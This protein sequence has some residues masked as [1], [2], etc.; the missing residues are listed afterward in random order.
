MLFALLKLY[1]FWLVIFRIFNLAIFTQE[2]Q[3][4]WLLPAD[5][6]VAKWFEVKNTLYPDFGEP[7]YVMIKQIDIPREMD[8]FDMLV[9][10]MRAG[11]Q[12]WNV[13]SVQ[14]WH[15]GFRWV[16]A[17]ETFVQTLP[18]RKQVYCKV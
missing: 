10:K 14:P 8:N 11:N 4:E 15:S 5:S 2:Y 9:G 16:P 12:S 6:E 17:I 7:G 18:H 3:P 13:N 1:V